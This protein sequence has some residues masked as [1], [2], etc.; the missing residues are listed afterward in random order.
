MS[1]C[2]CDFGGCFFSAPSVPVVPAEGENFVR[3]SAD[4]DTT[5]IAF[6]DITDLFFDAEADAT[7]QI[8][9]N[10]VYRSTGTAGMALSLLG[11]A[12]PAMV[13][14]IN[15]F[16]TASPGTRRLGRAYDTSTAGGT[17]VVNTDTLAIQRAT[18]VNGPTPGPIQV[19]F[20]SGNAAQV[21]T[22]KRGSILVWQKVSA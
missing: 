19:R 3:L 13:V 2:G 20:A 18:V 4:R 14:F 5:G 11:P 1:G 9:T 10:L 15:F 22:V 17:I 6:S 21:K 8:W 16:A 12:A 7:Y